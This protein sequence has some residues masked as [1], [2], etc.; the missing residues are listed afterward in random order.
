METVLERRR[1]SRP[2][3]E[4]PLLDDL[5]GYEPSYI[6]D[7]YGNLTPE[8]IE[9]LNDDETERITLEK[10]RAEFSSL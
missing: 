2:R 4:Y 3:R 10:L 5:P 7:I 8:T 6:Y 9:A 1:M